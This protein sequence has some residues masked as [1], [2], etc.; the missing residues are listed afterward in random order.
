MA[1]RVL[2]LILLGSLAASGA[3]WLMFG[4][5]PQRTGWARTEDAISKENA[6]SMG[7]LW[8]VK[9]DNVSKDLNSLTAAIVVE[10]VFTPRGVKDIAIV[11]G[12]SDNIYAIDD[13]A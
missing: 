7:V 2:V 12:S 1:Q 3:D 9:L 10:N 5:D 13:E 11:A 8:K 6:K 4:G